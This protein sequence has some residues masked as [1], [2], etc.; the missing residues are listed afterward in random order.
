MTLTVS[1]IDLYETLCHSTD[2]GSLYM[3]TDLR[4]PPTE[5]LSGTA[6]ADPLTVYW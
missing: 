2:A 1:A 6:I 5:I 4:Q 3:E